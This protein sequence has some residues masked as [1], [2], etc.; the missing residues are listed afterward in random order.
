MAL[1]SAD[2]SGRTVLR[3][4]PA[5]LVREVRII[6][7]AKKENIQPNNMLKMTDFTIIISIK[8]IYY[9]LVV[10]VS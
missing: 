5:E 9:L 8:I 10:I 2:S 4:W 7:N 1:P 3:W 6:Q